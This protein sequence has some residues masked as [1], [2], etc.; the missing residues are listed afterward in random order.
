VSKLGNV[1]GDAE[2][3]RLARGVERGLPVI[4]NQGVRPGAGER[5]QTKNVETCSVRE[6]RTIGEI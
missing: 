2:P 1:H 3:R 5:D 6:E 4:L